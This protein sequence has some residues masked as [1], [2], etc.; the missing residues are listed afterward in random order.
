[1]SCSVEAFLFRAVGVV[2]NTAAKGANALLLTMYPPDISH[3]WDDPASGGGAADPHPAADPETE[4]PP[5]SVS[6]SLTWFGWSYP[7]TV[8]VLAE[9]YIERPTGTCRCGDLDDHCA[10]SEYHDHVAALIVDR[11]ACDPGR[12]IAALQSLQTQ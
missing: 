11:I 12:A 7:A 8:E 1:M 5:R 6:G 3:I 9:H 10:L 2:V 4:T